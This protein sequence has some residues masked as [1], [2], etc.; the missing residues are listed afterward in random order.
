MTPLIF[1]SHPA[2]FVN[3]RWVHEFGRAPEWFDQ[4]RRLVAAA[5]PLGIDTIAL[6]RELSTTDETSTGA[7]R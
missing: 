7:R 3:G 6:A 4:Y 5:Q 1:T 2:A